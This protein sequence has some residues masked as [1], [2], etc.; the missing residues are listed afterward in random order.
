MVELDKVVDK[1]VSW[2]GN[3]EQVEAFASWDRELDVRVYEGKVEYLTQAESSGL[4]VRVIK[5][6]R[7]GF[8]YAQTLD[9]SALREVLE[10]ARDNLEFATYDEYIG[11]PEPDGVFPVDLE[12]WD[13]GV[14]DTPTKLKVGLA[15]ELEKVILNGDS[16]IQK[17]ES[18]NYADVAWEA[19]LASTTGM[20]ASSR[21]TGAFL[22]AHALAEQDGD[23]RT[24]GG[25]S[26][27]R[28]PDNLSIEE[29]GKDTIERS[30]RLLGAVKP[31]SN[32]L[33]VVLDPRVAA[34]FLSIV[35]GTLSGDA[36]EKGR[37]LFAGRISETV[38]A[39]SLTLVEDPTNPLAYLASRFDA[40]G[41]ACRPV[42]LIENGVLRGYLYDTYSA[43]RAKVSSTASASRAGFASTPGVGFRAVNCK[44]GLESPDDIVA[45]IDEGVL[46][47]S[48]SGVHSGVNPISGDFSVGAEGLMIRNGTIGS[49]IKEATIASTIQKMLL[50]I[51]GIGNDQEWLPGPSV[52]VTMAISDISL[53]GS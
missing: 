25:F 44:P 43:R 12:L 36:V 7:Q 38:G 26:V 2:A 29:A 46:V 15:L 34:T 48:I 27:G 4:G 35:V 3:D 20:K 9:E 24:G 21:G 16:R 11:L 31:K 52:G 40:E 37:S 45:G 19:A 30:T 41:L 18:S 13:G 50:G 17:V 5:N 49:P 23:V 33:T 51:V 10:E 39:E 8:A 6:G 32:R 22:T 42:T 14:L 53:S 28:A 47:C 1:V